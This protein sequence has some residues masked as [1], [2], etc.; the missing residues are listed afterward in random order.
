MDEQ[1]R[2]SEEEH[3]E[4]TKTDTKETNNNQKSNITSRARN[5]TVMLSPEMTGQVRAMLYKGNDPQQTS[6]ALNKVSTGNDWS[7]P[8]VGKSAATNPVVSSVA[9]SVVNNPVSPMESAPRVEEVPN[10]VVDQV[11]VSNPEEGL[12]SRA[13]GKMNPNFLNQVMSS[14]NKQTPIEKKEPLV[15]A[16]PLAAAAVLKPADPMVAPTLSSAPRVRVNVAE[17]PKKVAP[18]SKLIGFIVSF[19]GNEFGEMFEVRAGRWLITSRPTDQGEFI[20][21]NDPSVSPMHAVVRVTKEGKVQILDQ[22]SE[23]GTGVRKVGSEEEIDVAGSMVTV[24]HGDMVRFGNRHFVICLV[25][26]FRKPE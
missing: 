22:L 12:N 25:P 1:K 16:R 4:E 11:P 9:S 21:I 15:A 7:R 14:M 23:H 10:R 2:L 24:E 20:F 5:R 19:D 13:T 17:E 18:T 6:D 8:E 3:T 26:N